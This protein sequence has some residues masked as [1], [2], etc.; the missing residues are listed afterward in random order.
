MLKISPRKE[1]FPAQSGE[2]TA[3]EANY[4]LTETL[5]NLS[6]P[7]FARLTSLHLPFHEPT[8]I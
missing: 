5:R 4:F 7:D 2:K 1:I 8:T 3:P 6:T